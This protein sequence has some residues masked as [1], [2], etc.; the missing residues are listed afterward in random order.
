MD[1]NPLSTNRA[2]GVL[3]QRRAHV[4][5]LL[6]LALM[7]LAWGDI[8]S[9]AAQTA[10]TDNHVVVRIDVASQAQVNEL[11]ATLDVWQVDLAGGAVTAWV[12]PAQL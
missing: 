3:R 11:A 5:L 12:S 7:W 9:A 6:A 8:R 4:A 10:D 1:N 2:R